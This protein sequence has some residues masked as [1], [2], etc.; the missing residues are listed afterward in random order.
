M[1]L[2]LA[3]MIS[4]KKENLC[5]CVKSTGPGNVIYH[6]VKG[7]TCIDIKDKINVFLTQGSEF[8]VRVEAG[9][10]LQPLIKVELRG[11]TLSV[12]NTN[13]CNWVRGYKHH[14]D[15]YITAPYFK[16]ILNSGVGPITT[17]NT[18]VQDTLMCKTGNSGEIRLDANVDVMV[19]S[20]H[21]NGDIYLSGTTNNLQNDY[22][23]TNYLYAND[24]VVTSY[25]YLHSVSIGHAYVNAPPNGLMDIV[26]DR[27][28]NIYY[29]G[30]PARINL[31]K[32]D[33][34]E[35]IQQ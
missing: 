5:D 22:T 3:G 14:I 25:I 16:H 17:L 15:V 8:E 31:V 10:N 20:A 27:A 7:F 35:L 1:L 9:R 33:K 32:N 28:G 24:L 21:G 18:I 30:N 34:G 6:D 12:F 2:L 23:G 29:K 4:C 13:R 19:C 26:M 11:D